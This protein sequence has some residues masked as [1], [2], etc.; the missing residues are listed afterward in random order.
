SISFAIVRNSL[1]T[2]EDLKEN[3]SIGIS[4]K[5]RGQTVENLRSSLSIE[6]ASKN[7]SVLRLS[8][9]LPNSEKGSDYFNHLV[10]IYNERPIF[11]KRIVS[12]NTA[13]CISSRV[14]IIAVESGDVEKD[15]EQYK[16]SNQIADLE[17]EVK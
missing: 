8:A 3:P 7:A 5:S 17:T 16:N 9:I 4:I 10:A 11:E 14:D 2:T 6:P 12:K 13:E 15:V 1:K